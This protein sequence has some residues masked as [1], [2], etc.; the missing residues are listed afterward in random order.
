MSKK[1]GQ[2]RS[3]LYNK[4]MKKIINVILLFF[5]LNVYSQDSLKWSFK[6]SGYVDLKTIKLPSGGQ[7]INLFNNGT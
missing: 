3:F 1:L 2:Q 4:K 7:I 5:T 6:Y